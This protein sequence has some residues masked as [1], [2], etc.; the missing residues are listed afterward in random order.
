MQR[1]GLLHEALEDF[2]SN[3][4]VQ[5]YLYDKLMNDPTLKQEDVREYW[6][7]TENPN[8]NPPTSHEDVSEAYHKAYEKI[9][10]QT[11][12]EAFP[13]LQTLRDNAEEYY[14]L[15]NAAGSYRDIRSESMDAGED[16]FLVLESIDSEIAEAYPWYAEFYEVSE[17]VFSTDLRY[18]VDPRY[19]RQ[20]VYDAFLDKVVDPHWKRLKPQLHRRVIDLMIM[21]SERGESESEE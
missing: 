17:L 14:E 10:L 20:K 1:E 11:L 3:D 5:D 19:K 8:P 15:N 2:E 6:G 16:L 18:L 12:I 21:E 4:V 13:Q 9:I 7:L